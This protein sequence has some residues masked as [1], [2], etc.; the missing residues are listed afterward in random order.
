[1]GNY[2][3]C[4]SLDESHRTYPVLPV[5]ALAGGGAF[6]VASDKQCSSAQESMPFR[7]FTVS[8][9]D[10]FLPD[11][12]IPTEKGFQAACKPPISNSPV[13]YLKV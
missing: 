4:G 7:S 12:E 8:V 9:G 1:M 5:S 13:R 6:S 10:A 3:V 2:E 11:R